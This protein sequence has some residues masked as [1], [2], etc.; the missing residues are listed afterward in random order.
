MS[1][2]IYAINM[3][4]LA[5]FVSALAIAAAISAP[6]SA[7]DNQ[8]VFGQ[9]AA[10]SGPAAELGKGVKLGAEVYFN[11]VNAAGGIKGRKI[12][13]RSLDDGYEPPRAEKNTKEL[14][15]QDDVLAL[16]GYVGTPTSA[17]SIPHSTQAKVPFVGAYTGAEL[18]RS[19]FNKYIFN[20][21][22]SYFDE[23]EAIVRQLT[24]FSWSK[25]AVFYQNDSYGEAGLKGVEQ[26]LARRNLKVHAKAT[27][28]RNSVDIAKAVET[29]SGSQPEAIVLISTY[30][31]C[32]A[33]IKAM[34]AK[35]SNAMMYNVSFV[36][37]TALANALGE[38]AKGVAVS[39]VVPSPWSGK[40]NIVLEYRRAMEAAG[41]KDFGF[42]SLEGYIAAKIV[43]EALKNGGDKNREAFVA[44]LEKIDNYDAGGMYFTFSPT[45][46]GASKF[47]DLTILTAKGEVRD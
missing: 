1:Y 14:I 27:V 28:E 15:A 45:R 37:T 17:I 30:K 24:S 33:F 40:Y 19:P 44:A 9:S 25:V 6:A 38:S 3:K 36:G 22:A 47:V 35:G 12:V 41:H 13:L 7:A 2:L 26:A 46:H 11:K 23:T 42:T 21:R 8:I 39:Q 20:V 43:T 4:F 5:T 34:Q 16:F 10:L 18:L 31:S 32:A 29:L